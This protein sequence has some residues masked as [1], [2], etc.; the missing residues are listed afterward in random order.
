M[1]VS[2]HLAL[3]IGHARVQEAS[4]AQLQRQ[5]Q[6]LPARLLDRLHCRGCGGWR[7]GCCVVAIS[8][9]LLLLLQWLR[10]CPL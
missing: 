9:G 8:T 4:P 7:C 10:P 3:G 5:L 6:H 1:A 2:A